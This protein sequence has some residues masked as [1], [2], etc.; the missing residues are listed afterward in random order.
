MEIFSVH[1]S[2]DKNGNR[3]ALMDRVLQA[4]EQEGAKLGRGENLIGQ[5]V[6]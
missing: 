5:K 6:L 2:P 3:K 4:A 1:G